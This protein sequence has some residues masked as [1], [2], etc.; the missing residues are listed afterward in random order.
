MRIPELNIGGD[1]DHDLVS[2]AGS[3]GKNPIVQIVQRGHEGIS[4][5]SAG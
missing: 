5:N 2:H 1:L 4:A 3:I